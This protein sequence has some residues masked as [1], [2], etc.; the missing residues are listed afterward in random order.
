MSPS[1]PHRSQAEHGAISPVT[2][3]PLATTQVYAN[4]ML[5]V[6]ASKL[7]ELDLM[8]ASNSSAFNGRGFQP[9]TGQNPR[10]VTGLA[11]SSGGYNAHRNSSYTSQ[12]GGRPLSPQQPPSMGLPPML[13]R[14]AAAAERTWTHGDSRSYRH[15]INEIPAFGAG[16]GGASNGATSKRALRADGRAA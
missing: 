16:R 8:P 10:R 2:K 5:M 15:P 4:L 13:A 9:S 1:G 11:S 12:R 7:S 3:Q 14:G 6:L